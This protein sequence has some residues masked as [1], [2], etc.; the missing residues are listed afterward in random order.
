MWRADEPALRARD[1]S[2]LI[3]CYASADL[4]LLWQL[5]LCGRAPPLKKSG[6]L[7]KPCHIQR[8]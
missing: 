8:V 6:V 2:R 3:G 7:P 5:V 4:I 1:W